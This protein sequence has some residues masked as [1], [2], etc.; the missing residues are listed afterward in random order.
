MT[1]IAA[2][3]PLILLAACRVGPQPSAPDLDLPAEWAEAPGPRAQFDAD[4]SW[5]RGFRDPI[6]DALV[7]RAVAGNLDLAIARARVLEARAARDAVAGNRRPAVAAGAGYSRIGLS[8]GSRIPGGGEYDFFEA[9]FDARWEIDL[10]GR[11]D[12]AVDAADAGVAASREA[13][14]HAHVTLV[15]ELVREYVQYRGTQRALA[16]LRGNL[17]TQED[18]LALTRAR[19]DAGFAPELDTARATALVESTAAGVPALEAALRAAIHRLGVLAGESPS[20]L[21][22]LLRPERPI[23]VAPDDVAP[24]VPADVVRRRPDV[25]RAE[26]E[27]ARET[28]LEAQA[29]AEL[30]PRLVL[31]ASVGQEARR[32]SDLFDGAST[33]WSLGGSLLAPLFE[34]GR[35]RANLRAQEARRAQAYLAWKS[36]VLTALREV[37]DA[38]ARVAGERERADRL[39]AAVAASRR[40]LVLARDLHAQG[41]VDF[42]EVLDA[43]RALLAAESE[44]AAAQTG[45]GAQAAALYKALGGAPAI[46]TGG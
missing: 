17:R 11:L 14:R 3:A 35:L 34:G 43:Q 13:E 31:G 39:G 32:A 10:F 29:T 21:S 4:A 12:R 38:L 26:L 24:G 36:T 22:M 5:W 16:I 28:A 33:A 23:P 30:Y 20:A 1:R 44:L 25:R 45:V 19:Q 41:I 46:E 37:E 8:E 42:L 15:G 18:T 27:L 7:E 6:L 9:G 40:S 2:L